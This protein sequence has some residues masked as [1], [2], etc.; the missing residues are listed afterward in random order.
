VNDVLIVGA[1]PAG[2]AAAV[3][4]ASEGLDAL[5]LESNVP[6]GQAGSS[7][8]I[9]NYLGFPAGVSGLGLAG[10]AYAQSSEIRRPGDGRQRGQGLACGGQRYT[11]E[12]EGGRRASAR[13]VIIATGASY[14]KP[15]L[16]NLSA[17]E[18]SGVYYGATRME[19]QL[20][21][22]D[23]VIV[24]GGGN[25]AGQPRFRRGVCPRCVQYR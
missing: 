12:M 17:F 6:G 7:S 22:S 19:A 16:D 21:I 13:T 9:E 10:R 3:Y 23:E 2:L 25:S 4:A 1:G 11:V 5:V 14:R 8:R 20:S 15:A 18:G 24:V